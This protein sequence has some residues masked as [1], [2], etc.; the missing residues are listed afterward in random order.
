MVLDAF[1][2]GLRAPFAQ[3]GIGGGVISDRRGLGRKVRNVEEKIALPG[4]EHGDRGVEFL[5]PAS[6]RFHLRFERGA[7]LLRGAE[8]SDFLA[9]AVAFGLKALK[10]GVR[11][12]A[13]RVDRQ[14]GVHGGF[15]AGP[16]RGEAGFDGIRVFANESNIEHGLDRMNKFGTM[17]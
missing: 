2:H 10:A 7:V 17:G 12:A 11:L 4:V 3:H 15:V 8:L 16:A 1:E 14:H 5:H 13:F 6:E 9:E